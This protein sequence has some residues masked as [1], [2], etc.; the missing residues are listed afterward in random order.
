MPECS[1]APNE[2]RPASAISR[3]ITVSCA[4]RAAGAAIFLGHR[5]AEQARLRRALSQAA[6]SM[7]PSSFHCSTCGTNSAAM[8][9][10]ACSSSSTRSSVIQAGR[11][12]LQGIHAAFPRFTLSQVADADGLTKR[13]ALSG[14]SQSSVRW[15]RQ[16]VN[17]PSSHETS[18]SMPYCSVGGV[19]SGSSR[20]SM[21][22]LM[23][24]G[25]R[26]SVGQRRAAVR[27][28]A[29][30]GQVRAAEDRR[31]AARPAQMLGFA[32]RRTP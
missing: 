24:A 6:R 20:L 23:S 5:G 26:E 30:L 1:G 11:G 4:K 32:R 15:R 31:R 21:V 8:K 16:R 22:T 18:L 19:A 17:A 9:R 29:A 25:P 27:A 14:V 13:A 3:L 12:T 10:R 2:S 7:M 28:E